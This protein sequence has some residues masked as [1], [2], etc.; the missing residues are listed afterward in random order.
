MKDKLIPVSCSPLFGGAPS[1]EAFLLG[2]R[3]V[4]TSFSLILKKPYVFAL[5]HN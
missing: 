5:G 3:P 4:K 2:I 1:K